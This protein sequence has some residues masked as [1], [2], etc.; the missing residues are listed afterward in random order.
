MKMVIG[1]EPG[2]PV[3][4]FLNEKVNRIIFHCWI[5]TCDTSTV[6]LACGPVVE[7]CPVSLHSAYIT[8][9]M[10]LRQWGEEEK[11][12]T[13]PVHELEPAAELLV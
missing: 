10:T 1:A 2:A 7:L 3:F 6:P 12:T 8:L 4:Y 13:R 5:P 11:I 9:T